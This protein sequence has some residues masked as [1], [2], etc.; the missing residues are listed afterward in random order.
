MGAKLLAA[1]VAVAAAAVLLSSMAD[2]LAVKEGE[3]VGALKQYEW[4][5]ALAARVRLRRDEECALPAPAPA[6]GERE[7]PLPLPMPT[8]NTSGILAEIA[9]RGFATIPGVVP[10]GLAAAARRHALSV[11]A[12]APGFYSRAGCSGR[13]ELPIRVGVDSTSSLAP[14]RLARCRRRYDVPLSLRDLDGDLGL[15]V[16]AVGAALGPV[17]EALVGAD[18]SV[19]E[20]SAMLTCRG[21]PAQGLHPDSD[22]RGT[23]RRLFTI[24]VALQDVLTR[25]LGPTRLVPGTHLERWA[26]RD[27]DDFVHLDRRSVPALLGSGGALVYDS[28][29]VHG[30]GANDGGGRALLLVSVQSSVRRRGSS[31]VRIAPEIHRTSTTL[32]SESLKSQVQS[33]GPALDGPVYSLHADL[34]GPGGPGTG[35]FAVRDL[36][37]SF[38]RA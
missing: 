28:R 34:V 30:A 19:V 8:A 37:G 4:C 7:A 27:Q 3:C 16:G 18:G 29:A 22:A 32:S 20:L 1:T 10:L 17:L 35:R 15:A 33:P 38:A 21:S 2:L 26:G 13:C 36:A 9:S 11:V 23:S 14:R 5:E 31:F 25:D 12:A 24:F 6:G